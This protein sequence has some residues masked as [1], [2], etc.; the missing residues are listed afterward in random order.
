MLYSEFLELCLWKKLR[1]AAENNAM[2]S[3]RVNQ[4]KKIEVMILC[5]FITTSDAFDIVIWY[6]IINYIDCR[7][8]KSHVSG[9]L[10]EHI[11]YNL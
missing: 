6:I 11:V 8:L 10:N 7:R 4:N 2:R 5:R 3:V 1:T 9:A